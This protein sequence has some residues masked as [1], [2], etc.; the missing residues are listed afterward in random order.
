M[1]GKRHRQDLQ[2]TVTGM[3]VDSI[4]GETQKRLNKRD[5]KEMR[6][7]NDT[8]SA[9]ALDACIVAEERAGEDQ[10]G[11]VFIFKQLKSHQLGPN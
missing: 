8:D 5:L 10:A 3:W 2:V 6:Q 4:F 1:V 11:G 9:S 7:K